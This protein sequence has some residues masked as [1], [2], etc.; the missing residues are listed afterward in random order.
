MYF[1]NATHCHQLHD[2][3]IACILHTDAYA[4]AAAAIISS[5]ADAACII[6]NDINV[7]HV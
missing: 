4:A 7:A 6:R 1:T 5:M 3:P 2:L